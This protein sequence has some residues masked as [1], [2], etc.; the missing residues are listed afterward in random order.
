MSSAALRVVIAPDSFKGSATAVE[1]AE[2]LAEGWSEE[3]PGDEVVLAPMAD[4]GE[5]TV[6]AFEVA[7][8]RRRGTRSP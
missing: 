7:S 3:R 4:G 1:V 5:G 2:A 6:D 8:P